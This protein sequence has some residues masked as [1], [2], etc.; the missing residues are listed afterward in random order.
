MSLH[1]AT[2]E[3]WRRE[4]E[5]RGRTIVLVAVMVTAMALLFAVR[6]GDWLDFAFAAAFLVFGVVG[7]PLGDWALRRIDALDPGASGAPRRTP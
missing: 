4:A 3:D 7:Y 6:T 5:S 1:L 2:K